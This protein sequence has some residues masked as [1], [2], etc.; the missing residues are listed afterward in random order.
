[1]QGSSSSDF[2]VESAGRILEGFSTEKVSEAL[3]TRFRLKPSQIGLMLSRRVVIKRGLTEDRAKKLEAALRA[4]GLDVSVPE[5]KSTPES[6]DEQA[7]I[8]PALPDAIPRMPVSLAYRVGL[9]AVMAL[10][11][12]APLFYLGLIVAVTGGLIWSL[13]LIPAQLAETGSIAGALLTGSFSLMC[14]VFLLFLAR[15][16]FIRY[17]SPPTMQLDRQKHRR[18]FNL[19]DGL[20]Q[21]MDL[22]PVQDIRV[23][24]RV[25]ASLGPSE[26]LRSLRRGELT[27][28]VGLP[29]F[30]ALDSRQMIGVVGH[31]LGHF[32]H[33][34][35]MSANYLVNSVNRWLVSR[36]KVGD[37]WDVRLERWH[38][39]APVLVGQAVLRPAQALMTLTRTLFRG[40]LLFNLRV[41]HQLSR[42]MEYEADR[43]ECWLMG[44]KAF[45]ITA[46]KLHMLAFAEQCVQ[47]ANT[48][49]RENG[50]LI[51]DLPRA[52]AESVDHLTVEQRQAVQDAMGEQQ[53]SLWDAHPADVDRIRHALELEFPGAV[54]T[55]EPAARLLPDFDHLCESITWQTYADSGIADVEQY[56]VDNEKILQV[57]KVSDQDGEAL[58]LYF[59]G[60]LTRRFLNLEGGREGQQTL[61]QVIDTLRS[62]LPE[63]SALQDSYVRAARLH[64]DRTHGRVLLAEKV[65]IQPR[66]FGL[67]T[68]ELRDADRAVE[69]ASNEW[70]DLGKR[71]RDIDRL[72]ARRMHLAIDEMPA[73]DAKLASTVLE[74][75][76]SFPMLV[77]PMRHMSSYAATLEGVLGENDRGRLKRAEPVIEHAANRCRESIIQFYNAAARVALSLPGEQGTLREQ[78]I[79][80]GLPGSR[81]GRDLTARELDPPEILRVARQCEELAN[82]TYYRSM[83]MMARLCT[84]QETRMRVRPLKLLRFGG[85]AMDA[86][87]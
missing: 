62:R 36:A 67:T 51:R 32:A 13:T 84:E 39:S 29:L 11:L 50:K 74:S 43:Y 49:A 19:V 64:S 59:N 65:S 68:R 47:A 15:P 17:P 86:V 37:S 2:R 31:E 5:L 87:A 23:D 14:G 75:L 42:K 70:R 71:L 78:A 83:A 16:L 44:S 33:P 12:M 8:E 3:A 21:R 58:D 10:S 28:T 22:P 6:G 27:L 57:R 73:D 61:Q 40:M 38:G 20:C 82:D 53:T 79:A 48:R 1:M 41:S 35:A 66:D 52:I 76:S 60:H 81:N 45:E 56:L 25:A 80:S 72:F 18:F 4:S 63:L 26:G 30:A 54:R 46:E 69:E 34:T 9:I 85:G 7:E 24:N 77:L 55:D